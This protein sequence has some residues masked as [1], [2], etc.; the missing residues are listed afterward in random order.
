MPIQLANLGSSIILI[1]YFTYNFKIS[2][3]SPVNLINVISYMAINY[4]SKDF[5]MY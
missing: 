5:F 2:N 1:E 4:L 3:T